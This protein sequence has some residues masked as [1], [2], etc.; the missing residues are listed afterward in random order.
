MVHL[1]LNAEWRFVWTTLSTASLSM[2][3]S[4]LGD[5]AGKTYVV[6]GPTS[7]FDTAIDLG[8][9]IGSDQ[10]SFSGNGAGDVNGDGSTTSTS[11][12]TT[13]D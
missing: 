3:D 6:F 12:S 5:N 4:G 1:W 7:G 8:S 11:T 13:I 10:S 2:T 9:L